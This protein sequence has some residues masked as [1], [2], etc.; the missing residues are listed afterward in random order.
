MNSTN[1]V[2]HLPPRLFMGVC[3]AAAL[4]IAVA[5]RSGATIPAWLLP[6]E[7][8]ATILSLFLLGSFTYQLEK[9]ALTYGM[10][11]VMFAT[12]AGGAW[13]Q[14]GLHGVFST[15][16]L[17]G[18]L[19]VL[20]AA[21]ATP[22]ALFLA[23]DEL[24]HL[25]TMLFFLGLTFFVA[26]IAHTRVL[27]EAAFYLLRRR[28]GAVLP[29]VIGI[30]AVVAVASGILS[31]VSMIGLAIRTLVIIL[32]LAQAP[33][34]T[35]RYAVIVCTAVTTV[36]GMWLA[37]GEPPNLI[38]K[39]NLINPASGTPYLT[40]GFFLMYCLPAAVLTYGCVAWSLRQEIGD[41]RVDLATLDVLDA[42]AA[43]VR[44]LQ[45]LRHGEVLQPVEFAEAHAAELGSH[46][47][48]VVERT[49][50]GEALGLALVHA[51]VAQPLRRLLLGRFIDE[52]LADALDRH[53]VLE[54]QNMSPG[55]D[56][57]EVVIARALA[58]LD[59]RRIMAR[60]IGLLA[61][62][63]FGGLL[64]AHALNHQLPIFL[65]SFAGFAVAL[66]AIW[67][68]PKMRAA[69]LRTAWVEFSEYLFL[70]PL[71]FSISLLTRSE[72]FGQFQQLIQSGSSA[73][74]PASM[75][76]A[77][78]FGSSVLSALLDNNVVADFAARA[79]QGLPPV[80]ILLFSMSQIA[81]YALGG[82]WTH[83]GSAQ[84]VV[85][86]A[87]IRR[88]L[89]PR[90]GPLQY[91]RVFSPLLATMAVVL[92]LYIIVVAYVTTGG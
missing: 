88:D 61:A 16:E 51:G 20:Q 13:A 54:S 74:G 38:M 79:I 1:T 87:F 40:D 12:Y 46:A 21:T 55:L 29:T 34:H 27:E 49:R 9:D 67:S 52:S 83:I 89:D 15:A 22:A 23:V 11:L 77:Q 56:E 91:V 64:V 14:Q 75:A 62:L 90:F 81:G 72:F 71:F 92:T 84:S 86:Y 76:L 47:A 36:C 31:G 82:C 24:I 68:L 41:L 66:A 70:L 6:V 59:K 85:A 48:A 25:D 10:S 26:C 37:Y 5:A 4:A 50:T 57:G 30:T 2:V 53:Y 32:L 39:A 35:V 33:P 3:L 78:F 17:R 69:A 58:Q 42:N 18:W 7:V 80:L 44:F 65:A 63:P 43:S 45:A 19:E 73:M 8:G 60:R 28:A